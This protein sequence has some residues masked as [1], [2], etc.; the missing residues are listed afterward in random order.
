MMRP[1]VEWTNNPYNVEPSLF[2]E[3]EDAGEE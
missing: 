3:S 1:I 2:A